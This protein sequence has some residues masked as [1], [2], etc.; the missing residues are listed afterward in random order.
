MRPLTPRAVGLRVLALAFGVLT[1]FY[2]AVWIFYTATGAPTAYLGIQYT[3]E[4]FARAID[5]GVVAPDSPAARAGV[6]AGDR[7]VA[8]AGRRLDTPNPLY[9]HVVR[10]RPGDVV[11]VALQRGSE[12]A[13]TEVDVQ[14]G[15][16]PDVVVGLLDRLA[17]YPLQLYPLPFLLVGLSVL[18]LRVEDRHA[19]LLALSFA[20]L[21]AGPTATFESVIHPPLRGAMLGCAAL[22]DG[23]APALVYAL[24][25]SFPAASPLDRRVPWLKTAFIVMAA[26]LFAPLALSTILTGSNWPAVRAIDGVVGI[27]WVNATATAYAYVAIGLGFV[28]VLLN[29]R[30]AA[31]GEARRKAQFLVW[32]FAVGLVPWMTLGAVSLTQGRSPFSYPALVWAPCALLVMMLPV[33]VAYTIVRHRVFEFPVLV[34]RGA[35]YL[36]VQRGFLLLSVALSIVLTLVFALLAGSVLPR[37][38]DAALPAGIGVGALFGLLLVS[39]GG[40][41]ARRVSRRIDRAFFR[42]VYDASRLLEDLAQRTALVTDRDELSQLLD[43]HLAG[44]L[45]PRDVSVYLRA[46][47]GGLCLHLAPRTRPRARSGSRRTMP[48][49]RGSSNW[50]SRGK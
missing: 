3:Y 30:R 34:R 40:A 2:C 47:S 49:S 44:A 18:A 4:G 7:I 15:E 24:L 39:T 37:L 21:S 20:G 1:T 32:S 29:S 8:I 23:M 11:R 16:R 9:D 45:H 41:L 46:R 17:L 50:A 33:M 25:S 42:S 31:S 48:G 6:E 19:W 10:G 28:S 43:E 14:I 13:P 36:L 12:R 27:W 5:V 38:T 26:A 22:A 35:R